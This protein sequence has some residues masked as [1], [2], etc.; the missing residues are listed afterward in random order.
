MEISYE[1]TLKIL[2]IIN[3]N[4]ADEKDEFDVHYFYS[5]VGYI[6]ELRN[7]VTEGEKRIEILRYN[8][9]YAYEHTEKIMEWLA[10]DSQE[11]FDAHIEKKKLIIARHE[12]VLIY[13]KSFL[14]KLEKLLPEFRPQMYRLN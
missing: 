4:P 10:L 8:I 13:D 2:G 1:L 12:E 14:Q 9:N 3:T 7:F 11:E 5:V 6:F